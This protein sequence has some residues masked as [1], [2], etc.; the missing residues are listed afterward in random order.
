MLTGWLVLVVLNRLTAASEAA[1]G[2]VIIDNIKERQKECN[3]EVDSQII[4]FAAATERENDCPNEKDNFDCQDS[5][6]DCLCYFADLGFF[7]FCVGFG[8]PRIVQLRTFF[9]N[10]NKTFV[11]RIA[12]KDRWG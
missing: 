1:L 7:G 9:V 8:L 10:Y 4:T 3:K 5:I 12:E 2:Q 11:L 6:K